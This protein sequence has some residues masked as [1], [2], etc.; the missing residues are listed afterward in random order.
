M[1][2]RDEVEEKLVL[3][4]EDLLNL[5][6]IEV[7]LVDYNSAFVLTENYFKKVKIFF[8]DPICN[9]DNNT[10][11]FFNRFITEIYYPDLKLFRPSN[12]LIYLIQTNPDYWRN[13]L[14][15]EC[16]SIIDIQGSINYKIGKVNYC[17]KTY[18][19]I[20]SVNITND[21]MKVFFKF[22]NFLF[23]KLN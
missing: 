8:T 10:S 16:D 2:N 17:A 18:E 5:K 19:N 7:S 22:Q 9:F 14:E 1:I 4:L 20:K 11:S 12:K 15:N 23:E 21:F 13:E 6:L 3:G